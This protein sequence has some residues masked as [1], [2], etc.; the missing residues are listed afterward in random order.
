MNYNFIKDVSSLLEIYNLKRELSGENF[1][2]FSI[3]SME[4]DE[5]FTHSALLAELLNPKGSH[6]LGERPLML[7][8]E[9]FLDENYPMDT[10][11][12]SCR[13][14][15]HIG[16]TNEASTEGGRVDIVVKDLKGH[17][18]LIENKIYAAEQLNQLQRY[19]NNYPD[20][21]LF[22]LTLDGKESDQASSD[23]EFKI[24]RNLSYKEDICSWI[25]KCAQMAYDKPMLR[26]ILNQ[27]LHLI[28]KLTNSTNN[29]EMTEKITDIITDNFEA[30][31]EIYKNFE[32]VSLKIKDDLLEE[33]AASLKLEFPYLTI[34]TGPHRDVKS[35][36]LSGFTN[37]ATMNFRFKNHKWPVISIRP[38]T[39]DYEGA[40]LSGFKT[41]TVDGKIAAWWKILPV[42]TDDRLLPAQKQTT[43]DE[44]LKQISDTVLSVKTASSAA[45]AN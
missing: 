27:Y 26:E 8:I 42:L 44:I 40:G 3:M 17:V 9:Q 11:T 25:E 6:G 38:E 29:T 12:A 13:K 10:T 43:H 2:I 28:K 22:Y 15:E 24:Y 7:F 16:F 30:C 19:R 37:G 31:L 34:S 23:Q 35:I 32:R 45:I 18:I 20:A 1:N 5:V 21:E 39:S 4:S 14:E 41:D 36:K 33:M